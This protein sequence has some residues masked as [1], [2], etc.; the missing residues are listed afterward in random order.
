M[1]VETRAD[2]IEVIG[3]RD[4]R[5]ASTVAT[6]DPASLEYRHSSNGMLLGQ[7]IGGRKPVPAAADNDHVVACLKSRRSPC[8]GPACISLQGLPCQ[9]EE[10][11]MLHGA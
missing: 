3:A 4:L 9:L 6:A 5:I 7:K 11:V 2:R 1:I 8:H 10:R